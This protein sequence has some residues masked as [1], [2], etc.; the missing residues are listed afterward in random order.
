[1]RFHGN[2]FLFMVPFCLLFCCAS[3]KS[4]QSATLPD[5]ARAVALQWKPT[6]RSVD[7]DLQPLG[8]FLPMRLALSRIEDS[9]EDVTSVGRAL[10]SKMVEGVYVP[11]ATKASVEKWCTGGF[12]AALGDFGITSVAKKGDLLLECIITNVAVNDA[13]TQQGTLQLQVRVTNRDDMMVWEGSVGG[14]STL[15]DHAAGSD[16]ISECLSNTAMVTLYNLLTDQSF[17]DA[18]AKSSGL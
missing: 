3:Q 17:R 11:L 8:V 12:V 15:Y 6:M 1:M 5:N 16:G 10:E 7:F 2:R 13:I 14:K 4:M 18:V 9:R